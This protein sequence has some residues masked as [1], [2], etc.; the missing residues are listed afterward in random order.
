MKKQLAFILIFFLAFS[1]QFKPAWSL[2]TAQCRYYV[3]GVCQSEGGY[4]TN[5]TEETSPYL[6]EK[7]VTE[8]TGPSLNSFNLVIMIFQL[9]GIIVL[10][11]LLIM[12]IQE[13]IKPDKKKSRRR[14]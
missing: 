14:K 4:I 13:L 3:D 2:S 7:T 12:I 6:P 8:V 11:S 5:Y 9:I 10:F 1:L